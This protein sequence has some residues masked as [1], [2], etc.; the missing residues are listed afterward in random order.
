MVIKL[1]FF[2]FHR[3]WIQPESGLPL[4]VTSKFQINM[5]LGDLSKMEN[6]QKF[7]NMYLPMLWFDIVS[8]I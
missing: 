2:V 8:I 3:F 1:H 6:A 7:S 5:A 4:Q